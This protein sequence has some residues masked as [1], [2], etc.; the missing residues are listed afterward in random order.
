MRGRRSCGYLPPLLVLQWLLTALL[1]A[2]QHSGGVVV[3]TIGRKATALTGLGLAVCAYLSTAY[4]PGGY[5]GE[6]PM[7]YGTA[8]HKEGTTVR[9]RHAHDFRN[10]IGAVQV[11]FAIQFIRQLYSSGRHGRLCVAV[12]VPLNVF[13]SSSSK[14]AFSSEVRYDTVR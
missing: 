3:K 14:K 1:K 13:L 11:R 4:F 10:L 8:C 7:L 2:L 12:A 9:M 5:C 6:R